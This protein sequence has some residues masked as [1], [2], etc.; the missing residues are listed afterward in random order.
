[1]RRSVHVSKN[2]TTTNPIALK[3]PGKKKRRLIAIDETK[4]RL[5]K[6]QIFVW[7]AIGVDIKEYLT[8]GFRRK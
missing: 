5:E 4:I 3:Q 7:A 2:Y 6:K 8:M 1:M